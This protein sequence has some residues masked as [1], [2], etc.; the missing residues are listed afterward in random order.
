MLS[1]VKH[2]FYIGHSVE[3]IVFNKTLFMD[4]GDLCLLF[5]T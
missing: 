4:L 1:C 2:S 3:S 5:L